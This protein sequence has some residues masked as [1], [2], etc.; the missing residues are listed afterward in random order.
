MISLFVDSSASSISRVSLNNTIYYIKM[1]F[2]TRE[3]SWYLTL[4]DVNRNNILTGKKLQFGVSPTADLINNPLG[5]N[6][7]ILKNTE[8]KVELGRNNF[9]QDLDYSLVYLTSLEESALIA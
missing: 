4:L 7:Y 8:S 6:L 1:S 2:S 3:Q 9:G 5:G